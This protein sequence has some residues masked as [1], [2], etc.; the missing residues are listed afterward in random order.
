MRS[1]VLSVLV[2]AAGCNFIV[3][4]LPIGGG[5]GGG[6]GGGDLSTPNAPLDLAVAPPT[7]AAM[8]G[9]SDL[10]ASPPGRRKPI[11]IDNTKV[12]GSQADF[13]VWIDL[14]DADIAARAQPNGHDIYFTAA[15]GTT[16]LDYE[17]QSWSSSTHRLEAWVRLPMLVATAPTVFYVDYGDP[18]ATATPNPAGVF[19]SSF[20]AVWHLDDALPATSIADATGTHAGTPSLTTTTQGAAKLGGGL[21]FT[22]GN[23]TITFTNPLSGNQAHTISVWVSQAATTHA[24][25]ILVVGSPKP[26]QSRWFY[27]HFMSPVLAVGFYNPDWTT[28]TDLDNAGWTLVHWVFEGP[29]GMNHLYVNGAEISGSPDMMMGN[30]INTKGATGIIGHAP[31][32]AYG[33]NMGLT[34]SIDELRIATVARSGGWIAT[35]Y[36]NQSSPATFY[37]VGAEQPLP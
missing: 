20:A 18:S 5:G 4:G 33:T 11:T 22:G 29:N 9:A 19:K 14:T 10:A 36:A 28:S 1:V 16:R 23:D 3:S 21:T 37:T 24:S 12:N 31:E 34:G 30:A 2:C 8:M 17:I 6:V 25:A 26:G 35:E 7:D 32:P 13:P 27:G 15:D